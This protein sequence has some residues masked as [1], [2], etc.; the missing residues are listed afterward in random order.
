MGGG[1]DLRRRDGLEDRVQ[2]RLER[3]R[4]VPGFLPRM[5]RGARRCRL[6]GGEIV[7]VGEP[8]RGPAGA[9]DRVDHRELDLVLV[10]PQIDEERIDGVQ[11]LGGARVLPIDLVDHHHRRQPQA[12]GL[13]QHEPRLGEGTL[14]SVHQQE[15]AVDQPQP[16]LDLS[17]EV[18]VAR[19]VDDVDL[20]AAV[21]HRGVLGQDGDALLPLQ[22]V[23]VHRALLDLLVGPVGP[24][25]A[26][27]VVHQGGLS[28]V[29]VRD[30]GD[31]ADLLAGK[32]G[33]ASF[34]LAPCRR[35]TDITISPS[36]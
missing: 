20:H 14:R 8:Q 28:V 12:E 34:I 9:R 30:D 2:Q 33:W 6:P 27:E 17:A 35:S 36:R 22:V 21:R 29:D 7:E 25:L 11:H 15:N 32:H 26:E 5:R 10:G 19:G 24:G 31:V 4:T 16:A 18:C 23:G 3:A 1:G 13:G